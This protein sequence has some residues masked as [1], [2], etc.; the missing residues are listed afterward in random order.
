MM[1]KRG[2]GGW[3]VGGSIVAASVFF[4]LEH[5]HTHAPSRQEN[6]EKLITSE[7][8]DDGGSVGSV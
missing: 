4:F 7:W 5:T 6:C 2:F 8:P 3:W 1:K